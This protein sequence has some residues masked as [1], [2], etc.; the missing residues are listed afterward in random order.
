VAAAV[1]G[2]V[3]CGRR[4]DDDGGLAVVGVVDA[5]GAVAEGIG[6]QDEAV[7]RVVGEGGGPVEGIGDPIV[8]G[9]LASIAPR[10][11]ANAGTVEIKRSLC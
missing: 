1:G 2:A 8:L 7:G 5:L 9:E 6:L 11:G 4:V 3:R 10:E